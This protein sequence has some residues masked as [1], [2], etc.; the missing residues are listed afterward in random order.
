[1]QKF[2]ELEDYIPVEINRLSSGSRIPFNVF[3]KDKS[4]FHPFVE[5]TNIFTPAHIE[6]LKEKGVSKVYAAISERNALEGYLHGR[7]DD[8]LQEAK[9]LKDYSYWK[10]KY[11]KIDEVLLKTGAKIDFSIYTSENMS[12]VPLLTAADGQSLSIKEGLLPEGKDV[13]IK[14]EDIY[15]YQ[16]Y[17][18][19][20]ETE[21]IGAQ[22]ASHLKSVIAKERANIIMKDIFD[23]NITAEKFEVVKEMTR[24][25]IDGILSNEL[26]AY[27]LLSLK[28]Q[29]YYTYL[30]SVNVGMLSLGLGITAGLQKKAVEHLAVGAMLHDIGKC[31]I[32]LEIL[33]KQGKLNDTE[34][35][36]YRTHV[37]EGKK[38]IDGIEKFPQASFEPLLL[39]HEK[40]T[41]R[42]YPFKLRGDK[43]S[44]LGRITGIADCYDALT[45]PKLNKYPLTPYN[46]LQ[47]ICRETADYDPQLLKEFVKMMG[48]VR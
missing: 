22:D 13:L 27:N 26:V 19:T 37:V 40:L 33:N 9:R 36:I 18:K 5:K 20:M 31:N 44:L 39:H 32:P 12:F 10:E 2:R 42:G 34:F 23:N 15:L 7:D 11:F 25:I 35:Q 38:I 48:K 21:D 29:D 41:G 28:R 6:T 4:G 47:I 43:I 8:D 3:I 1:M 30:H 24:S 17:L 46:A 16:K 14:A 45:T